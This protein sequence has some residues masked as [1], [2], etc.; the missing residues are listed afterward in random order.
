[1]HTHHM[2]EG[3]TVKRD[4][5][6]PEEL[7]HGKVWRTLKSCPLRCTATQSTRTLQQGRALSQCEIWERISISATMLIVIV[8]REKQSPKIKMTIPNRES[9]STS[10]FWTVD[11]AAGGTQSV[12]NRLHLVTVCFRSTRGAGEE[13]DWATRPRSTVPCYK[14]MTWHNSMQCSLKS[15]N[16]HFLQHLSW[17]SLSVILYIT[18]C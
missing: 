3:W 5:T 10:S 6:V 4:H 7:K 14:L 1:M 16:S 12:L 8:Q 18:F 2:S 17:G 15:P 11:N 9:R 13:K